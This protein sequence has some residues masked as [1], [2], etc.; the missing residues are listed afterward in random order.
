MKKKTLKI[1]YYLAW[2]IGLIA[3]GFLIYGIVKALI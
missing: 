3:A 2:I 1:L